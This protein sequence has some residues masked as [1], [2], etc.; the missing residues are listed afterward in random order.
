M[1]L[2]KAATIACVLVWTC[3][4]AWAAELDPAV[5]PSVALTGTYT[6]EVDLSITAINVPAVAAQVTF[7]VSVTITPVN[8]QLMLAS[9]SAV[10]PSY[11]LPAAIRVAVTAFVVMVAVVVATF[12]VSV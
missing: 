6:P 12:D 1:K 2:V 11:V 9:G 3:A 8:V 10:L 7:A 5:T 4:A